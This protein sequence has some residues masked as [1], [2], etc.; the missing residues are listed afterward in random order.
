MTVT[1]TRYIEP[2]VKTVVLTDSDAAKPSR[3][4]W[5]AAEPPFKGYHAAPSE[6]YQQSTGDTAIVIDNGDSSN[7]ACCL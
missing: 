7:A 4:L 6:G 1:S 3:R 5:Y 2:V